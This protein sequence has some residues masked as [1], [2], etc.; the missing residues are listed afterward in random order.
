MQPIYKIYAPA[1]P[2]RSFVTHFT[3]YK[4]HTPDYSINRFLPDGNVEIVIDLTETPKFIYDDNSLVEIQAC[5]KLW[6]SGIRNKYITIPSGRDSEMFVINFRKGMA[7]PFLGL[8]LGDLS[9][10][11]VDG[12]LILKKIFLQLREQ[13]FT[14]Y[15]VEKKFL[16]AELILTKHFLPVL[17]VDPIIEYAVNRILAAP[18]IVVIKSIA[19]KTGYSSRHLVHLFK[20]KV[21]VSP[22]AFLKI[23]RFQ[24]SIR[25]IELKGYTNFS[26]LASDCGYY[27]QSHFIA[28]FKSFSGFTPAAYIKQ[29]ADYLNYVPI[30]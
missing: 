18:E 3:Y 11:V 21:G 4:N 8:P 26:S 10:K 22:K 29:K 1:L 7:Y 28:D 19:V 20:H 27:D 16:L 23:I 15:T 6:I 24:K 14:C 9:D 25:E 5:N 13:L 2:L 30:R 17:S 12:D